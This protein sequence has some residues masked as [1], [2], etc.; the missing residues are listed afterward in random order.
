M[1]QISSFGLNALVIFVLVKFWPRLGSWKNWNSFFKGICILGSGVLLVE[2]I[3]YVLTPSYYNYTEANLVNISAY[4]LRGHDIYTTVDSAERY[5]VLYGPWATIMNSIFLIPGFCIL[6]MSKV[7]GYLHLLLTLSLFAFLL[8]RQKN[9]SIGKS[10]IFGLLCVWFLGFDDFSYVIRPDSFFNYI[11]FLCLLFSGSRS[12]SMAF[13]GL[14][15][16]GSFSW[17][18]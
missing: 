12:R 9:F 6:Q 5:S 13:F 4:W 1:P 18:M 14:H 16:R 15:I 11:C 8:L 7:S 10:F 3:L 17:I 2:G